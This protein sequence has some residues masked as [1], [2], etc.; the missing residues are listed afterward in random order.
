MQKKTNIEYVIKS[1]EN[2]IFEK[3]IKKGRKNSFK[4]IDFQ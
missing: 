3:S 1:L 4:K 2:S